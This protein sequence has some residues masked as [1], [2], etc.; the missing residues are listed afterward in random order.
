MWVIAII[1]EYNP[2]H[3]GH[4]WQLEELRRRY[5]NTDG[6]VV[7][8]SGSITQRGE[9]S[10]LDKWTR[11]Q[12]AVIGGADLV[13]E[14]PFVFSCRSAQDFARGGISLLSQLGIVSHLAFGTE[15]EDIALLTELSHQIDSNE[16]QSR[17][18]GYLRQ[19]NSYAAALSHALATFAEIEEILRA[20]NNILAVEYLRALRQ[21]APEITPVSVMRKNVQHNDDCLHRGITS[22][23][24]IRNMLRSHSPRWELLC[25]SVMSS[26]LNDLRET[27][28]EGLPREQT[29]LDLL[30]YVFLTEDHFDLSSFYG[31]S[32]GIENRFNHY[33]NISDDYRTFLMNVSTKRYPQ[34]RIARLIIYLL[35]RFKKV[36]AENFD[37]SGARYIRPLAF[38]KCG[39]EL[40]RHIKKTSSLPIISRTAE[41]LTTKQRAGADS[42]QSPLQKMLSFDTK[43]TELRILTL[44]AKNKKKCRT[45]FITSPQFLP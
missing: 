5:V 8:M 29:L 36:Q 30:R 20:P 27:H 41:F 7:A 4:S 13:L 40:L 32:E 1:A 28:A 23:S 14:L 37:M 43:A 9:L 26:V 16:V 22:A 12:H 34:S 39:R 15:A 35:L 24:S 31:I 25:E 2:F 10:V 42:A 38:N 33:L 17:L 11:A 6:I 3:Y 45:D 21:F 18:S 19:G 44:A